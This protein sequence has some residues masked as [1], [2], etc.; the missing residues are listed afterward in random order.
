MCVCAHV[1]MYVYI[2]TKNEPL[3]LIYMLFPPEGWRGMAG[4]PVNSDQTHAT[5][6]QMS[7]KPL[8]IGAL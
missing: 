2:H 7:Y 1:H 6:K 4:E 8:N 5:W 3:S